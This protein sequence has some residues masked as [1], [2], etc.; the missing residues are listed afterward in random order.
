ARS[1]MDD[2]LLHARV[3]G[4]RLP[5]RLRERFRVVTVELS[6]DRQAGHFNTGAG[7][8]RDLCRQGWKARLFDLLNV[9]CGLRPADRHLTS[10]GLFH[11]RRTIRLAVGVSDAQ[12]W[13]AL[14][15]PL[16][17]T[18]RRLSDDT[19]HL[20]PIGLPR[21]PP[22]ALPASEAATRQ[23]DASSKAD[24]VCLFS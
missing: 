14:R 12:F 18:V 15:A 8:L 5:K 20:Y 10:G 24:C 22:Y 17:S 23:H 16:A 13:R 1:V 4:E 21:L 2:I 6:P 11:A 19:L 3:G 7:R 9:L